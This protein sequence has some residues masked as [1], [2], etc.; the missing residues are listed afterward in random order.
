MKV[1]SIFDTSVAN[2]NLGNQI[3]TILATAE[4]RVYINPISVIRQPFVKRKVFSGMDM[5]LN[6]FALREL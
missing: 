4:F 6:I 3:L 1:I 2:Y 5:Q